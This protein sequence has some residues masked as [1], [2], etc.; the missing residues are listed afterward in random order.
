MIMD[1]FPKYPAAAVLAVAAVCGVWYAAVTEQVV[2]PYLVRAPSL[3]TQG[4]ANNLS[5]PI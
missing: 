5:E 4:E 2:D 3:I 1:N